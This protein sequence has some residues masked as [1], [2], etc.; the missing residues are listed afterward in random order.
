MAIPLTGIAIILYLIP[1]VTH[2][3][4][5]VP[6]GNI[7]TAT[8][9]GQVSDAESAETI[10]FVNILVEEANRSITC[11]ENGAFCLSGLSAGEFTVKTF[12]IGYQSVVKRVILQANNT[13][14]I[15]LTLPKAPLLSPDIIVEA[16]RA[17]STS[18]IIK[19]ALLISDRKLYQNL[20]KTIAETIDYEPGIS[21]RT[22]GPAPARPVLRGLD[23][24]R[25][26]VLEDGQIIG[27]LSA[28]S[29]DHAVVIEPVTAERIEII[30]GPQALV[31]GSNTLGGVVNVARHSIPNSRAE[32]RSGSFTLQNETVNR[33]L[34]AGGDFIVPLGVFTGRVDASIRRAYDINTPAGA[35]P[36]TGIATINGSAG[37]GLVKSWG[38]AGVAAGAFDSAYGIPPDP[39][40]GHPRGVDIVME[41]QHLESRLEVSTD[42]RF[43]QR[44]ELR[45]SYTSYYHEELE[46]NGNLGMNFGVVTQTGAVRLYL[47]NRGVFKNGLIGMNGQYRD[48]ASGGLSFTPA[49]RELLY[50]IY[51]YREA[52]WRNVQFSGA[53]RYD[54]KIITP[55]EEK[56][57]RNTGFIRKRSFDGYAASASIHYLPMRSIIISATV[58]RTFRAPGVEELF[59]EGPHLAAYS[60][61]IGNADLQAETGVGMEVSTEYSKDRNKLRITLFRNHI[62]NYLL[63]VNTGEKSWRRADLYVYK[64]LGVTALMQGIEASAD[65]HIYHNFYTSWSLGYVYG[66]FIYLKKP[67]PRIPPLEGKLGLHYTL[68]NFILGCTVNIADEQNRLGEFEKRTAGYAIPSLY[69]Q[70]YF[71]TGSLL[72][73][74]TITC[75]N[76]TNTEYRQHLN[77]VKEVMPEPGRNFKIL[78]KVFL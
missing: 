36:N 12:R 19:P 27:D 25:L 1:A 13:T 15:V 28:T 44:L 68:T 70:Y 39:N 71:S 55:E 46:A 5:S 58:L 42:N 33:G 17:G 75:S 53:L 8:L 67:L 65:I 43:I 35:L 9:Q 4:T 16:D 29:A 72:N 73:T 30:R 49:A 66:D 51:Y 32:H 57:S 26:P 47:Q 41:R 76:F 3:A 24:D 62:D 74:V 61:D 50:A 14:R 59:S 45:Q 54:R 52:E 38:N 40:G 69:L 64:Y 48:F 20:G 21:Q 11:D 77:R 22:M 63:P 7:A 78:Y 60:Y 6:A 2:A 18:S 23:G 37:I 10:G 31:Y 34:V 56:Y